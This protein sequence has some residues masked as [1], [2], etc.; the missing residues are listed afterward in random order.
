MLNGMDT[1]DFLSTLLGEEDDGLNCLSHSPIGSDSGISEDTTPPHCQS[2]N[3]GSETDTAPSPGFDPLS[4]P[5]F[6]T[7]S[8]EAQVVQTDH[9]Y[10]LPHDTETLLSVRSENPDSDVLIDVG[11]KCIM[12]FTVFQECVCIIKQ[13]DSSFIEVEFPTSDDLDVQMTDDFSDELPCSLTIEDYTQSS[14]TDNQVH[15]TTIQVK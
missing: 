3:D 7:E 8:Y 13:V 10:T 12:V 5:E 6:V 2:P 1:E 11:K 9:C 4:Y 14:K 15:E